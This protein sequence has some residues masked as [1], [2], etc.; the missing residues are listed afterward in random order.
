MGA[1]ARVVQVRVLLLAHGHGPVGEHEAEEI[2]LFQ[3]AANQHWHLLHIPPTTEAAW[4]A[5]RY[6]SVCHE[7]L[8]YM[9]E[10]A[11]R[12]HHHRLRRDLDAI[13]HR[14]EDRPKR[15]AELAI[16]KLRGVDLPQALQ[17]RSG[18]VGVGA[19]ESDS[20]Q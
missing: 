6:R 17:L 16:R 11:T 15:V 18:V 4:L 12:K 7:S 20:H 1:E 10:L 9:V 3:V 13:Y 2:A 14:D 8:S 19:S 5:P